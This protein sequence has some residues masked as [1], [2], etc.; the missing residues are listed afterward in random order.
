MS[1]TVRQLSENPELRI[2][3]RAGEEH[4]DR[5]LSW[6]HVSELDDPTAFLSGGELLLMTGLS[7]PE[8]AADIEERVRRL[9]GAGVAAVG[10]GI[11][12][13]YEAIPEP[14]VHAARTRQLPLLEI[15]LDVPFIRL[16]KAVSQALSTADHAKLQLSHQHQRRLIHA[17]QSADGAKTLIRRTAEIIG[18]WAA[19]LDPSGEV[20]DASRGSVRRAVEQTA[21]ARAARPREVVFSTERG[22][23]VISHPL[24]TSDGRPLGYLV[25][26][27]QGVVGSLDHGVVTIAASLLILYLRGA[28]TARQT[29]SRIR[30]AV[31]TML[32]SGHLDQVRPVAGDLW[33]GLPAEPVTVLN[34]HGSAPA[35]TAAERLLDGAAADGPAAF[36]IVE[37]RLSVIVA[38]TAAT[39]S[40]TQLGS[41]PGLRLGVSSPAGWGELARADRESRHAADEAA[42]RGTTTYFADVRPRGLSSYLDHG[43][44]RTYAET[45]LAA[46]DDDGAATPGLLRNTLFVWLAHNG[47]IDPAA[48]ALR[49][50]RHTLRRRL[51]RIE[52]LLGSSLDSPTTRAELWLELTLLDEAVDTATGE[53]APRNP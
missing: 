17:T 23:D 42:V 29:L 21:Q 46:L 32:L 53:A 38:E 15:P 45:H 44:A 27:R 19:L 48:K 9:V 22:E 3:I 43:R 13:R 6:A 49:I 39:Q 36:G 31:L 10:F 14:F 52:D 11:G 2:T 50:H 47:H 33:G 28:E 7:L 37:D 20:V 34:A 40:A 12:L 1:I 18:G 16:E 35:L 41:I 8:A 51:D 5:Q 4:L 26:G 24:L 30:A 25:A